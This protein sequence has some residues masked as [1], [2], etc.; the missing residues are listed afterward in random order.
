M[1]QWKKKNKRTGRGGKKKKL[2]RERTGKYWKMRERLGK[3]SRGFLSSAKKGKNA[4]FSWW[5]FHPRSILFPFLNISSILSFAH[6][7]PLSSFTA[8]N[9]KSE[10]FSFF[11]PTYFYYSRLLSKTYLSLRSSQSSFPTIISSPLFFSPKRQQSSEKTSIC[12]TKQSEAHWKLIFRIW[13][14]DSEQGR[15]RGEKERGEE[16]ERGFDLDMTQVPNHWKQPFDP[17]NL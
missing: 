6:S 5:N 4:F 10:N 11:S 14:S 16:R 2:R 3:I 15:K 1:F 8:V 17:T 9:D 7:F 13:S 12:R